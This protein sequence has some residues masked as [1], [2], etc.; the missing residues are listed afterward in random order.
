MAIILIKE[1]E[2]ANT[3]QLESASEQQRE[4]EISSDTQYQP[5]EN[6]GMTEANNKKQ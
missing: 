6:K 4:T 5:E 2:E 3:M 1:L